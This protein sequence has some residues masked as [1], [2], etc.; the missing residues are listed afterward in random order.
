MK[1]RSVKAEPYWSLRQRKKKSRIWILFHLNVEYFVRRR[2]CTGGLGLWLKFTSGTSHDGCDN[3]TNVLTFITL[4][5]FGGRVELRASCVP[6]NCHI[7]STPPHFKIVLVA[8]RVS[9]SPGWP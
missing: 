6:R 9:D 1:L 5:S 7:T 3:Q 4:N 2:L 8:T